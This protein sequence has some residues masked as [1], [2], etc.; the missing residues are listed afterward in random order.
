MTY[1]IY[2]PSDKSLPDVDGYTQLGKYIDATGNNYKF[3]LTTDHT[4]KTLTDDIFVYVS[5]EHIITNRKVHYP[6]KQSFNYYGRVI[7]ADNFINKTLTNH[8]I[9][10]TSKYGYGSGIYGYYRDN[11]TFNEKVYEI[12]LKSPLFIQDKEHSDSLTTASLITCIFIDNIMNSIDDFQNSYDIIK[13]HNIDHLY[14]LWNIVF[15][16]VRNNIRYSELEEALVSYF[17]LYDEV[18]DLVELP[19]NIIA[20]YAGY[21]GIISSQI[22]N[23]DLPGGCVS[24]D[25]K[26]ATAINGNIGEF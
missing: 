10:K 21:D 8:P 6:S 24:F 18:G 17:A 5:K 7:A 9:S 14:N 23:K 11:N 16:R 12:K 1:L 26:I 20:K 19:T 3:R 22:Y 13:M 15:A 25:Y 2:I 4:G